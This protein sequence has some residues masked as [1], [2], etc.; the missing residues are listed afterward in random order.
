[1]SSMIQESSNLVLIGMAGCGKSSIGKM[2]AERTGL[3]FIDTDDLVVQSQQRPL[4]EIIDTEGALGFR[5]IEENILL[6]IHVRRY[7]IATG[8]SSIYSGPGMDHLKEGGLVIMLDADLD[9]LKK[10]VGDTSDR[11]LVKQPG[12]N[13]DD[14]YAERRSLYLRYAE[15]I[16]DCSRMDHREVC[17]ALLDIL[18]QKGAGDFP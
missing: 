15:I 17:T 7:V 12:Q 4:Q 2:L 16:I 9:V 1:M 18:K 5:R 11:G 14:L 8:G 6:A 13:F 10:R 3:S